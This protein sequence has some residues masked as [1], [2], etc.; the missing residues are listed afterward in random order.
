MNNFQLVFIQPWKYPNIIGVKLP[1]NKQ[2]L[3]EGCFISWEWKSESWEHSLKFCIGICWKREMLGLEMLVLG[4][5]EEK[6]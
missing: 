6:V 4:K 3:E 5:S 2:A 1:T